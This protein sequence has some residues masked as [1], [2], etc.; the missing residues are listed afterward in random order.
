MQVNGPFEPKKHESPVS[1]DLTLSKFEE[2]TQISF[3][4][5]FEKLNA[6]KKDNPKKTFLIGRVIK[7]E[8]AGEFV[9]YP[10]GIKAFFAAL[11]KRVDFTP[12]IKSIPH[13]PTIQSAKSITNTPT[14]EPVKSGFEIF[15]TCRLNTTK[16]ARFMGEF[17]PAKAPN[18]TVGVNNELSKAWV[19]AHPPEFKGVAQKLV[20]NINFITHEKFLSQLKKSVESFNSYLDNQTDKSYII[21]VPGNYQKSSLWVTSLAA[22]FLKYPPANIVMLDDPNFREIIGRKE[23]KHIAIFDD[24]SYSANQMSSY[25]GPIAFLGK[26]KSL[27]PIIPFMTTVAE[28]ILSGVLTESNVKHTISPHEIMPSFSEK[29]TDEEINLLRIKGPLAF[30]LEP[31][32]DD[33]PT[34]VNH[35]TATFYNH[36]MPDYLSTVP[37]I[38]DGSFLDDGKKDPIAFVDKIIPP[39]KTDLR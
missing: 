30:K 5:A 13:P 23:Y 6:L 4:T 20:D 12:P 33:N 9:V 16:G 19:N 28:N 25:L 3:N 27:H 7:G 35:L 36:K 29:L 24:A 34:G 2:K 18:P 1:K 32:S 15:K 14:I 39:Y 37:S 38:G 10:K 17:Y 22:D 21:V 26:G 8:N 11:F 31:V